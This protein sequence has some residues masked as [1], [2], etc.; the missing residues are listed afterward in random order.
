MN[1]HKKLRRSTSNRVISG[2]LGGISEYLGWN[3]VL[4]RIL[5]AVLAFT[6]G[7]NIIAII[8]YIIM[9]F[10]IPSDTPGT[11]SAFDQFKSTLSGG[12]SSDKSRKVIHNVEEKDVH[13]DQKR[14]Q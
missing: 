5:Y 3:A 12:T 1:S 11:G 9:M 8:G 13:D 7:I 14:G 4:V 10:T 6:P 2:V